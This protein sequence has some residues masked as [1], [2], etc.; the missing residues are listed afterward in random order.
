MAL[1]FFNEAILLPID[2]LKISNLYFLTVK[3]EHVEFWKET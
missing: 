2:L 3:A 1:R